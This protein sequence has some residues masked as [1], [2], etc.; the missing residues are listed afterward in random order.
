MGAVCGAS[1]RRFSSTDSAGKREAALAGSAEAIT[2]RDRRDGI[3][4]WPPSALA[5]GG[6]HEYCLGYLLDPESRAAD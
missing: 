6:L 2:L 3:D 1:A 4:V 5:D